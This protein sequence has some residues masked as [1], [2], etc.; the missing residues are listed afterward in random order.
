MDT[1]QLVDLLAADR[2]VAPAPENTLKVALL[3]AVAVAL[4]V[5][6]ACAGFRDDLAAAVGSLR[7]DFKL[8]LNLVLATTAGGLL[9]RLARPGSSRG[10]WRALLW[11]APVLLALGATA[12]LLLLPRAQWWEV[13]K[14]AN[15][16]WCLRMIPLL[17]LA[18]LLATLWSL[19]QAAPLRPAA[20]GAIAGLMSAGI[21]GALYALHCPDDSPLFVGI[22]Y[23]GATALVTALGALL[24]SRWLRW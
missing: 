2:T 1:K 15:S 14:G 13:A 6:L 21:G 24:G 20:T 18:P 8:L 19:R 11:A 17:A 16:T 10:V 9:L 23:V 12:E 3:P 7:F 5:F 4:V 22:W